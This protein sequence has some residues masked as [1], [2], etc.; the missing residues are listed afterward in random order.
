[1]DAAEAP[2][3]K[4]F[5]RLLIKLVKES[6]KQ[7]HTVFHQCFNV[8]HEYAKQY[9]I[10]S[11]TETLNKL[12]LIHCERCVEDPSVGTFSMFKEELAAIYGITTKPEFDVKVNEWDASFD[13]I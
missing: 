10:E 3:N 8:A 6:F 2:H 13:D 12:Y 5:E 7:P 1:M 4:E 11:M 9:N